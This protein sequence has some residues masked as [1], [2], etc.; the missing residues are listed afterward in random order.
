MTTRNGTSGATIHWDAKR[1]E[2]KYWLLYWVS[3]Y[4]VF[5]PLA[6]IKYRN[7]N[8]ALVTRDTDLVIEGFGRSGST[9]ANFAFLSAQNEP[10]KTV[11]HTHA[12]AQIILAAQMGIPTLAI[13]KKP[14]D[15]A[16]SHMVRYNVAARPALIAWNRFHRRVLPYRRKFVAATFEEVTKDFG[17]VTRKVNAKFGTRFGVFEHTPPNEAAIFERIRRRNLERWPAQMRTTALA[18]PSAERE[19]RKESLRPELMSAELA[20]LRDEAERLYEA[21]VGKRA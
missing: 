2:F 14:L 11:H 16:L 12:A 9:F 1:R 5:M 15:A 18:I 6:R 13:I 17:G 7:L 3:A 19:A 8:D 4:P 20:G 21:L 10:V